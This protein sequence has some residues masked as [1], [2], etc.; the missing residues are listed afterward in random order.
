[1]VSRDAFSL[2]H[3]S[4]T[5][6]CPCWGLWYRKKV[7]IWSL[8]SV[9]GIKVSNPWSSLSFVY[10]W[11]DGAWVWGQWGDE[12]GL[13]SSRKGAG[14][15]KN[16][17]QVVRT[18][19]PTLW[20]PGRGEDWKLSSITSGQWFNWSSLYNETSIETPKGQGSGSFWVGEHLVCWEGGMAYLEGTRKL[21]ATPPHSLHTLLYPSLPSVCS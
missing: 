2:T 11:D 19:S 7:S 15:W 4:Q 18:F 5:R 3:W 9:S 6:L 10:E 17:P 21:C 13:D 1:M 14:Y 16:Q 20:H 8:F 12:W